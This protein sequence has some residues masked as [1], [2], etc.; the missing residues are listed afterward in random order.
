MK[1]E[2]W[3]TKK[4]NLDDVSHRIFTVCSIDGNWVY[5]IRIQHDTFNRV[6]VHSFLENF[7][8]NLP[9]FLFLFLPSSNFVQFLNITNN[10]NLLTNW[11]F[12][13]IHFN[14]EAIVASSYLMMH[15]NKRMN[16]KINVMSH[17]IYEMWSWNGAYGSNGKTEGRKWLISPSLMCSKRSHKSCTPTRYAHTWTISIWRLFAL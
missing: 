17:F 15:K 12:K 8:T 10:E 5:N 4:P 7:L 14:F 13:F 16:N 9:Q 11:I 1:N 2:E 3:R 6:S